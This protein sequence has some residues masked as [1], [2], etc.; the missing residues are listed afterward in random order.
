MWER[1]VGQEPDNV[2]EGGKQPDTVADL[3]LDNLVVVQTQID[4]LLVDHLESTFVQLRDGFILSGV[5]NYVLLVNLKTNFHISFYSF[6]CLL[7][8][9]SLLILLLT[10]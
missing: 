7:S 4:E 2:S 9:L 10:A 1:A 6:R 3:V 5:Q 8:V